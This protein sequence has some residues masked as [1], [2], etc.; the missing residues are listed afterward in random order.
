MVGNMELKDFDIEEQKIGL[1]VNT[2]PSRHLG[3]LYKM[4]LKIGK[5]RSTLE[6]Y[7]A[8]TNQG[9]PRIRRDTF[10]NQSFARQAR[11]YALK[12]KILRRNIEVIHENTTE[13]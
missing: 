2:D 4:V 9:R 8:E 12:W 3:R 5:S 11:E 7:G 10:V 6:I 13:A 1:V